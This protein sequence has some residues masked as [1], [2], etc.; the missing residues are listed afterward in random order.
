MHFITTNELCL[1]DRPNLLKK[2]T[3]PNDAPINLTLLTTY[4]YDYHSVVIDTFFTSGIP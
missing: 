3:L 4:I 2:L 1:L